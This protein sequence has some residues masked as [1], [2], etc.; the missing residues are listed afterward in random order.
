MSQDDKVCR[1]FLPGADPS[2]C[3][4]C[5][6][7]I[8][9]HATASAERA[10]EPVAW[11]PTE[12]ELAEAKGMQEVAKRIRTLMSTEIG[13]M[14]NAVQDT[15]ASGRPA[16]HLYGAW[17]NLKHALATPSSDLAR[18]Q[19]LE[20]AL[21]VIKGFVCGEKNP[22]WANDAMTYYTRGKLADLCDIALGNAPESA[23]RSQYNQGADNME[24]H[25]IGWAIKQLGN[26]SKVR[27]AGWNGK[28]MWLLLVPSSH[29]PLREGTPYFAAL[30]TGKTG[31]SHVSIGA[32]IDMYTAQ[33]V[34][35]PGW[36]AS[37]ADLLATDWEIAE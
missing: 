7:K 5:G 17:Q 35:Q 21:K 2:R 34:M 25:G 12:V 3:A 22:N 26:G 11:Q 10:Q 14:E 6:V 4:W 29:V 30:N 27:R 18:M 32:H 19:R 16:A 13:E 8:D 9:E 1:D 33:G 28:G 36:L 24:E 23:I 37:Q 15:E 20:N 31:Q